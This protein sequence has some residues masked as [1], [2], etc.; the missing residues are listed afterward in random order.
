[1][2]HD[3]VTPPDDAMPA[4]PADAVAH[5]EQPPMDDAASDSEVEDEAAQLGDFA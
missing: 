2:T 1:M 4:T 5:P 3:P